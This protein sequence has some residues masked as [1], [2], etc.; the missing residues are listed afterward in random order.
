MR[1]GRDT[2]HTHTRAFI[3]T[4]NS[5]VQQ[6]IVLSQTREKRGKFDTKPHTIRP[7]HEKEPDRKN[8]DASRMSPIHCWFVNPLLPWLA[9]AR[10]LTH[11]QSVCPQSHVRQCGSMHVIYYFGNCVSPQHKDA[12]NVSP[13]FRVRN[14]MT[15]IEL[16][17]TEMHTFIRS[18]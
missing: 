3:R 2:T 17:E 1:F 4:P 12:R 10:A 8:M 9:S 6:F 13:H 18:P 15:K 16:T 5:T 14:V 7:M 11:T